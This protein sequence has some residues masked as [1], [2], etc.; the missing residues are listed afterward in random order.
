MRASRRRRS[1]GTWCS[2]PE[3]NYIGAAY[4]LAWAALL[5]YGVYVWRRARRAERTLADAERTGGAS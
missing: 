3:W 1:A 5:A 4:G 2:M